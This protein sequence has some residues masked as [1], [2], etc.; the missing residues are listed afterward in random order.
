MAGEVKVTLTRQTPGP[1]RALHGSGTTH[2]RLPGVAAWPV[3]VGTFLPRS[4]MSR[5]QI[6]GVI[7][8]SKSPW[9]LRR[10]WIWSNSGQH[11]RK[12]HDAMDQESKRGRP[13][14]RGSHMSEV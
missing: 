4:S 6:G 11:Y 14:A 2:A 12:L 9:S 3:R 1:A 13:S 10:I 7:K 8:I 5:R